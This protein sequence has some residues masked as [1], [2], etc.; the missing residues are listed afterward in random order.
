MVVE[1]PARLYQFG[2]RFESSNRTLLVIVSSLH[3]DHPDWILYPTGLDEEINLAL[4]E[5]CAAKRAGIPN[6]IVPGVQG[7]GSLQTDQFDLV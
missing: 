6:S 3:N 5:S 2:Q 1:A 4:Y 7:R